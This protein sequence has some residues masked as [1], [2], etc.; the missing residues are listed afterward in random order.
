MVSKFKNNVSEKERDTINQTIKNC[1]TITLVN[2]P[3][4][5]WLEFRATETL[6]KCRRNVQITAHQNHFSQFSERQA[7]LLLT[8]NSKRR[9]TRNKCKEVHGSFSNR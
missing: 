2:T 3:L 6:A 9:T 5:A 7:Q 4:H 8:S 1:P